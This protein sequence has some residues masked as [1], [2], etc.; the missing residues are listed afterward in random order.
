MTWQPV[1]GGVADPRRAGSALS[2]RRARSR[3]SRAP[4]GSPSRP[5]LPACCCKY[6]MFRSP[7]GSVIRALFQLMQAKDPRAAQVVEFWFGSGVPRQALVRERR[8]F[9]RRGGAGA[10]VRST[11]RAPP[12]SSLSGRARPAIAWRYRCCSIT[13]FPATCPRA[14]RA[15][16]A[17]DPAALDAARYAVEQGYDR[18]MRPVER[19]FVTCVRARRVARSAAPGL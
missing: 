9:R 13:L 19:M 11:R 18:S 3:A 8:G 4:T 12:G 17:T 14:R 16:F 10:S 15:R 6:G 1:A 2:S 5:G 7:G